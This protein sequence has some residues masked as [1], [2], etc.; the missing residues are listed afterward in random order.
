MAQGGTL[1]SQDVAPETLPP[2]RVAAIWSIAAIDGRHI[3]LRSR[4]RIFYANAYRIDTHMFVIRSDQPLAAHQEFLLNVFNAENKAWDD[5]FGTLDRAAAAS[6]KGDYHY[7]RISVAPIVAQ[8][9]SIEQAIGAEKSGPRFSDYVFFRTVPFLKAIDRDAVCPLLNSMTFRFVPAG[10]RFITQGHEGD[11]CYIVQSGRCQVQIE[12]SGA[13]HVISRIGPREFVGEMAL[14]TGE[15]RSAHVVAETDLQL[16]AIHRDLFQNLIETY[17]KVGTFLTEIM[18]ERFATRKLTADR[19]IGKYRITDIIGRGGYSIVYKGYHEDL[20]Q[21]VAVKMLNHDM[22]LNPEFLAN[23]RQEAQTIARLNSENIIKVYDIEERF[24]TIFIIMELLEGMTLRQVLKDRGRLSAKEAVAILLKIGNGLKYAHSQG[25]VHQDIKPGNIFILPKGG[26][27]ILDFGLACPCG[28]ETFMSGTPGYMSPEQVECLPV[29]ERADIYALG[30]I[31]YEM[32]I[33]KRP[34]E[35]T[36]PFKEMNLHVEQ[37]IP[38]PFDADPQI[39]TDLRDFILKACARNP[40]ARYPTIQ[41]A[42][43]ALEPLAYQHGLLAKQ[44]EIPTRKMST[45]FLFY[46]EDQQLLLNKLMEEFSA[47]VKQAGIVFKATDFEDI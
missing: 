6:Q 19:T 44:A 17:P 35:K 5:Y 36:D 16:W 4:Q 2:P 40:Q 28:T 1:N 32:L 25:L 46:R 24:R 18:A 29:D 3:T 14:L 21:A 34:F 41:E 30:L 43:A 7:S 26:V 11:N 31:A 42:I 37:P 9:Y 22:A 15:N 45:M 23:F 10:T 47:K 39:H 33:G 38:D 20:N 8:T 27:K 13:A 12:K